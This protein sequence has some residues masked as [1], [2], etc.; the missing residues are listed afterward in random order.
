M[1]QNLSYYK[2]SSLHLSATL[3]CLGT[4]LESVAKS[5]DGRSIFIFQKSTNLETIV[6][7]FWK[8]S[9]VVE[10]NSFWESIRSLKN[11][12]HES[13]EQFKG[14]IYATN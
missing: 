13:E 4:R 10:P 6:E 7:N 1:K 9:L 12:I 11:L 5:A 8:R 14:Y 2:T 3:L